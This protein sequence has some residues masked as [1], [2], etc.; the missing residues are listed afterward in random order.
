MPAVGCGAIGARALLRLVDLDRARDQRRDDAHQRLVDRSER[1]A[2]LA[3]D[4]HDGHELAE[5]HGR[6]RDLALRVRKTGERD[7]EARRRTAP[8][9]V[10]AAHRARVRQHLLEVA[11]PH[12]L[13]ASRGHADDAVADP[14][15]RPDALGRVPV[16]GDGE[17]LLAPLVEEEQ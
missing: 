3:L 7:L 16:A 11:H 17:E 5:H 15:L 8:L 10:G 13:G 9:L 4:R 1:E 6:H 2:A 12:R 14:H